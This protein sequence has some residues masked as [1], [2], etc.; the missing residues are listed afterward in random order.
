M[1]FDTY[2]MSFFISLVKASAISL[3]FKIEDATIL[4]NT[5]DTLFNK[6][7]S[8]PTAVA[9]IDAPPELQ[10]I[11]IAENCPLDP[12]ANCSA[13]PDNGVAKIPVNVTKDSTGP[14]SSTSVVASPTP[15]SK[16]NGTISAG[17]AVVGMDM[18]NL[19][20]LVVA[21]GSLFAALSML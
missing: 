3:G 19:P 7:C 17:G 14:S 13:Y 21:V 11:C 6:R 18:F 16:P 4:Y 8:P 15:S 5:L 9:G 10:S 20:V 1:D 12:K 2:Q